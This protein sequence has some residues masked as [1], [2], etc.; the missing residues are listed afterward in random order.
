[1]SQK[2][3]REE[4]TD[5]GSTPE[6]QSSSSDSDDADNSGSQDD[7]MSSISMSRR[8]IKRDSGDGYDSDSSQATRVPDHKRKQVMKHGNTGK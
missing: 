5:R 2:D 1:M 8:K 3:P 4:K 6:A 7:A